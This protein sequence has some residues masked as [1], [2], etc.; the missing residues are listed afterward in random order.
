MAKQAL[1]H[2]ALRE[3]EIATRKTITQA[4]NAVRGIGL[5]Q[6]SHAPYPAA[7]SRAQDFSSVLKMYADAT[8]S[9]SRKAAASGKA[10]GARRGKSLSPCR[11][12]PSARPLG[13]RG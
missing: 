4:P 10:A 6:R 8:K 7:A 2:I 12:R 5:P 1:C 3:E 11:R 13:Q 9:L